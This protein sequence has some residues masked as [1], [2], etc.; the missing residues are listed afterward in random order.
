MLPVIRSCLQ[1][2]K[3]TPMDR[4]W[5]TTFATARMLMATG[6]IMEL[7]LQNLVRYLWFAV[8]LSPYDG[9]DV[10]DKKMLT[11][12][13]NWN[14]TTLQCSGTTKSVA[15]GGK[16]LNG[17]PTPS[18]PP[19][20]LPFSDVNRGSKNRNSLQFRVLEIEFLNSKLDFTF[21]ISA[22]VTIS[23]LIN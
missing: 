1:M 13:V 17:A 7:L 2:Q 6:S 18:P 8:E 16:T 4:L 3:L 20:S 10:D 23:T 21:W 11:I 15:P 12:T 19:S 5:W 14:C 9:D 22:N